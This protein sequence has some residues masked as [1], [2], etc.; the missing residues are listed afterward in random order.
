VNR[1]RRLLWVVASL[2]GIAVVFSFTAAADALEDWL[3]QA[4]LGAY[5]PAFQDWAKIGIDA[6][7]EDALVV[8]SSSSRIFT[9]AETFTAMYGIPVEAYDISTVEILEKVIREQDAGIFNADVVMCGGEEVVFELLNE[10]YLYNFVPD[11]VAEDI[12]LGFKEPL[13]AQRIA[14]KNIF[15]NTEVY[16]QSPI[17]NLWDVTMPEWRGKVVIADPVSSRAAFT[18]YATLVE[19]ADEMQAAYERK[20][21]ELELHAGVPNAGYEFLYRLLANDVIILKSQKDASKAV[22]ERGQ[23]DP[24]LC[25]FNSYT[26]L[27]DNAKLDYAL[28]VALDVDPAV[29]SIN[30]SYIGMAAQ[31]LHPN[32]AKLFIAWSLGSP[33]LEPDTILEEPYDEGESARLLRGFEPYFTPGNWSARLDVPAPE[34]APSLSELRGISWETN[35][36]FIWNESQNIMDFWMLY[37]G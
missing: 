27:S 28:G 37:G 36:G 3:Q 35:S 17:D 26:R 8:Y 22:G 14:S 21:G 11:T 5:A 23:Q 12:P 16:P 9:M 19:H 30:P 25:L 15:F 6:A 34:G 24:P 32:A 1:G 7:A 2:I 29:G 31:A 20:Y 33:E 13:L 10:G 18:A 4:Q